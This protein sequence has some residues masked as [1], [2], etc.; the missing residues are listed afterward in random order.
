MD[1]NIDKQIV[2]SVVEMDALDINEY[3]GFKNKALF[4][5]LDWLRFVR[6]DS[7]VSPLIIRI[8]SDVDGRLVGYF[9]SMVTRKFGFKII[10]S[11]FSGWSTCWMGFD[12]VD[13]VDKM[14]LVKPLVEYLIKKQKASYIQ[15]TDRDFTI[16]Q[17]VANKFKYGSCHTL[18]LEINRTDEELFKVFKTDCRNFIRQFERRGAKLE[19]VQPSEEFSEQYYSQLQDVFAKQGMVP[20][21]SLGKVKCMMKHFAGTDRI[22]CQRVVDPEGNC[23]A[24]SIFLGFNKKFFFWGGASWRS[25]QHYRPN[26][27][28][29]WNAIKYWRGLGYE[30]F[31]MVG[32]RDYKRKFGPHDVCYASLEF[33]RFPFLL[34]LKRIAGI[35]YFKM[36]SLKGTIK[37]KK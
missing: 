33:A 3:Y 21:Y 24:T 5:T 23:I 15:I 19:I 14:T 25:G 31:D 17:A 22:L 29:I 13:G 18:E 11:P 2:F 8:T 28:M 26:E 16:E 7:K 1:I 30:I 10:G 37:G 35:L 9:T 20:T 27:Y 6:D 4:T 36:L 34:S 12:V 32:A